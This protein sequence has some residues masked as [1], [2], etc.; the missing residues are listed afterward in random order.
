MNLNLNGFMIHLVGIFLW[1]FQL[2]YFCML[3]CKLF[4]I[5][6]KEITIFSWW[7]HSCVPHMFVWNVDQSGCKHFEIKVKVNKFFLIIKI[8]RNIETK[9]LLIPTFTNPAN[10]F[11]NL[12]GRCIVS[13]KANV[14]WIYFVL[15][16]WV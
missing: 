13:F 8:L 2:W 4:F 11:E 5:E 14:V 12:T 16:D 10:V 15:N 1:E 6:S 9:L 7:Y 3:V